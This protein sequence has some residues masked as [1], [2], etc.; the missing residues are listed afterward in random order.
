MPA[1]RSSSGCCSSSASPAPSIWVSLMTQ[2]RHSPSPSITIYAPLRVA[3]D[4][5]TLLD[6]LVSDAVLDAAYDWLCLRRQEYPDHADVWDFRRRWKQEKERLLHDLG[7]DH[8]V[9]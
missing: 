7:S 4:P 5:V 3:Q 8:V 9:H 1:T 2:R 6:R